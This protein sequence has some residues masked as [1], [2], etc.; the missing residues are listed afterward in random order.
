MYDP[1]PFIVCPTCGMVQTADNLKSNGFDPYTETYSC[2]C[3]FRFM[4]E[5]TALR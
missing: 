4:V 2:G 3:G 5:L 1:F